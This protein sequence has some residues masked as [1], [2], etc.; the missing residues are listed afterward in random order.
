MLKIGQKK[1]KKKVNQKS[2]LWL[3]GECKAEKVRFKEAKKRFP[4]FL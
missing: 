2:R 4:K 3:P 1:K